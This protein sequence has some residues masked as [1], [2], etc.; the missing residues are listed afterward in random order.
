MDTSLSNYVFSQQTVCENGPLSELLR[1]IV[2]MINMSAYRS[3]FDLLSIDKSID[4]LISSD[5]AWHRTQ[6][7]MVIPI[8]V[9]RKILHKLFVENLRLN[10]S[11]TNSLLQESYSAHGP[12]LKITARATRPKTE[13]WMKI[14][15]FYHYTMDFWW[16]PNVLE[17]IPLYWCTPGR[18]NPTFWVSLG[19]DI[20]V[21]R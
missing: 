12:N 6:L 14:Y 1:F 21:S 9:F 2:S 15:Q 16:T 8:I 19:A 5:R 13:N 10:Q 18:S 11:M 3:P 20:P 7:H 4:L 17:W